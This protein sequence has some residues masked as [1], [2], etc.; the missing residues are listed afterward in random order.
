M[1]GMEIPKIE[2]GIIEAGN[3]SHYHTKIY[4]RVSRAPSDLPFV[5]YLSK[6]PDKTVL[7]KRE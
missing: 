1:A 4:L 7:Y 6:I 2:T 5:I 3:L